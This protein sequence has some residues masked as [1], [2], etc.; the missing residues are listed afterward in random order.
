M[1]AYNPVDAAQW[2]YDVPETVKMQNAGY[3]MTPA[4]EAYSGM[5][6][7]ANTDA[8]IAMAKYWSDIA[9]SARS[10]NDRQ[11]A[12]RQALRYRNKIA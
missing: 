4:A 7:S 8:D 11:Y 9:A 12:L 6:E 2:N 1:P 10:E 3:Q 5:L